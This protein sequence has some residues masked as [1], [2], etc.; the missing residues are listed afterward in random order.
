M[1]SKNTNIKTFLNELEEWIE[2][3][4]RDESVPYRLNANKYE[5]FKT[6]FRYFKGVVK[7]FG[8]KF[9]CIDCQP[10]TLR[11]TLTMDIP[12]FDA[13][14]EHQK[15]FAKIMGLC[16]VFGLNP[17]SSDGILVDVC[18]NDLWQATGNE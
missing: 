16:D 13:Y 5:D 7:E 2:N 3:T 12:L 17:S 1:N 8:G 10:E 9:T 4:H 18:V 11:A 15:E 6:V 14:G